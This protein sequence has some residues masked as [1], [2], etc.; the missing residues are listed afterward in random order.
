MIIGQ[1]LKQY[2]GSGEVLVTG[3]GAL[4]DYFIERL[5]AHTPGQ[6]QIIVP[7]KELIEFKEAIVFAL[8]GVLRFRN[9]VNCLK[10]VT[11]ASRDSSGGDIFEPA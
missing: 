5:I 11:G 9:E 8:M 7:E 4:N 1:V 10:S 6:I 3:G 2:V